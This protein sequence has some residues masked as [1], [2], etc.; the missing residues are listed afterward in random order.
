[1]KDGG[2]PIQLALRHK[3]VN[4]QITEAEHIIARNANEANFQSPRP[5]LLATVPPAERIARGLMLVVGHSYYSGG[6]PGG[7]SI[8]GTNA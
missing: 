1:M 4:K 7:S 5:N 2:N 6:R 8:G 3:V